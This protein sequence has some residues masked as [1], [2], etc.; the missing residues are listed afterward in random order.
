MELRDVFR[1]RLERLGM[2]FGDD[3]LGVAHG[4]V[5]RLGF[6][7]EELTDLQLM[8]ICVDAY[9]HPDVPVCEIV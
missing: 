1:L 9:R 4:L 6:A 3:Q 8:T 2:R 5:L 7:P